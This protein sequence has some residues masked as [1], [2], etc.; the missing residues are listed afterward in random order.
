[1]KEKKYTQIYDWK[2]VDETKGWENPNLRDSLHKVVV[3]E[4]ETANENRQI[5]NFT[6]SQTS[7][8]RWKKHVDQWIEEMTETEKTSVL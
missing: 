8:T 7:G 4:N 6:P 3:V 2:V 1:M 5:F